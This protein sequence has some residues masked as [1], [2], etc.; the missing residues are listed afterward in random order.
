MRVMH[1]KFGAMISELIVTV[2]S[3]P[4]NSSLWEHFQKHDFTAFLQER[5]YPTTDFDTCSHNMA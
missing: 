4:F 1:I 5:G 3:L 2:W